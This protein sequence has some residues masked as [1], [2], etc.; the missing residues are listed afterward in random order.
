MLCQRSP[1]QRP[2]TSCCVFARLRRR[3]CIALSRNNSS[4][5]RS[6]PLTSRSSFLS[7]RL[8]ASLCLAAVSRGHRTFQNLDICFELFDFSSPSF[9]SLIVNGRLRLCLL[10]RRVN[11]QD[12]VCPAKLHRLF[13]QVYCR[14]S[15]ALVD[16]FQSRVESRVSGIV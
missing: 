12:R 4:L 3:S 7:R 2:S 14:S 16:L 13:L 6:H 11:S 8:I 1:Y 5:M 10:E 9:Q 15:E